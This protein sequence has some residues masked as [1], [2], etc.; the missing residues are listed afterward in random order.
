M[1]KSFVV[2]DDHPLINDAIE[3]FFYKQGF[4]CLAKV[5]S[6]ED[7]VKFFSTNYADVLI[8]D[9]NI[10]Q[11][12]TF[13]TLQFIRKK[14]PDTYIVIF[15]AYSDRIFIQKAK[16]LGIN[17]YISK[18]TELA[19]L[20]SLI[21]SEKRAF[22]TNTDFIDHLQPSNNNDLLDAEKIKISDHEKKIIS[23]VLEGKTSEKIAQELFLSKYTVD[24]HRKN[25]NR[26]LNVSGIV[27]LQE[28]INLLKLF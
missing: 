26:K 21:Q 18:T 15:S 13:D 22:F 23:L 4:T 28:K 14:N 24:T 9:L 12:N 6:N 2:C 16:S 19:E 17:L 8:C 27:Q 3:I 10:D 5:T 20:F 25:I 7:L 11:D 1:S